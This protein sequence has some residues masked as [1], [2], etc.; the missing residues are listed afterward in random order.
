MTSFCQKISLPDKPASNRRF[1]I[2][3]DVSK[4]FLYINSVAKVA[5]T[6]KEMRSNFYSIRER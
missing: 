2:L 4:D 6:S 5:D 3:G 1:K